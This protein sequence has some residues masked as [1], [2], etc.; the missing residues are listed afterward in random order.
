MHWRDHWFLSETELRTHYW[1]EGEIHATVERQFSPFDPSPTGKDRKWKK[2]ELEARWPPG[3]KS[4]AKKSIFKPYLPVSPTSKV[5]SLTFPLLTRS[6][7][8]SASLDS[9][10]SLTER[11]ELASPVSTS[12]GLEGST[13]SVKFGRTLFETIAERSLSSSKSSCLGWDSANL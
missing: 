2:R 11:G 3:T 6:F 8:L 4:S 7:S 9:F 5:L 13:S 12:I 10:Q 1:G